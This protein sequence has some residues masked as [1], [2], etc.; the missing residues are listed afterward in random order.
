M[1]TPR[2]R[3]LFL[4]VLFFALTI[5]L[6]IFGLVIAI[7]FKIDPESVLSVW[8]AMPIV[9]GMGYWVYRRGGSLLVPSILA[10]LMLYGAVYVGVEQFPVRVVDE[11]VTDP[12]S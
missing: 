4:L 7:I 5:V 12:A 11:T 9:M 1:I 3:V 8:I 10:L 2:A 6:G